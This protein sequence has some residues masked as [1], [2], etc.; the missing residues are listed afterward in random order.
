[1]QS[2]DLIDLHRKQVALLRNAI[3]HLKPGG[4]LVYSTCSLEEEENRLVI[5]AVHRGWRVVER[6]PGRDQGDGFFAA[7]L[8][9]G[10]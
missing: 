8:T 7:M 9:S 2:S 10:E 1:L 5:E 4:R 6:L 3:E